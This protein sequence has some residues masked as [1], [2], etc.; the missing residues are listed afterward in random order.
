MELSTALNPKCYREKQ[1]SCRY[2]RSHVH[3]HT[4]VH[5]VRTAQSVEAESNDERL[6]KGTKSNCSGSKVAC[7]EQDENNSAHRKVNDGR[8]NQKSISVDLFDSLV[9]IFNIIKPLINLLWH[10]DRANYCTYMVE[11]SRLKNSVVVL[12]TLVPELFDLFWRTAF[13]TLSHQRV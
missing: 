12:S 10:L 9:F 3:A 2:N 7:S 11:Y 4:H 5:S 6:R 8:A 1:S 13:Q